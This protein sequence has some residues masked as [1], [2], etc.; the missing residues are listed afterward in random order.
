MDQFLIELYVPAAGQT[1]DVFIPR[2]CRV[3]EALQLLCA[4]IKDL[5]SGKII[6]NSSTMLCYEDGSPIDVN[7][8]IT[9]AGIKTGSRLMLI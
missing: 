5:A 2:Y 3:F 1:Y 7:M 4:A 9:D 8:S 6:P